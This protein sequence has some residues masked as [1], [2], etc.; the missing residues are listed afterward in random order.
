[1]SPDNQ[2][3]TNAVVMNPATPQTP[4]ASQSAA[5]APGAP[6]ASSPPIRADSTASAASPA[7]W[8]APEP[9]SHVAAPTREAVTTSAPAVAQVVAA[10]KGQQIALFVIAFSLLTIAS[11]S[12]VLLVRRLR[13]GATASL[14]TQS[15]DRG[16]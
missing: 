9:D 5:A 1:V 8:T 11:V 7:Q 15:I 2:P 12:V 13:G 6:P 14:I 16:R 10:P 4:S 3:A